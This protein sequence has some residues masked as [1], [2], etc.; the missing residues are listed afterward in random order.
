MRKSE[1]DAERCGAL[2][3]RAEAWLL[4]RGGSSGA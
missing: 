3:P 4:A 2:R 1:E